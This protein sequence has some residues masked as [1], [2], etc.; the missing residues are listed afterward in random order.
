MRNQNKIKRSKRSR[1]NDAKMTI[2]RAPQHKSNITFTHTYRFVSSSA[3][4]TSVTLSEVIGIA[5][6]Y[7][8]AA[9]GYKCVADAVKIHKIEAW[10]DAVVTN[11]VDIQWYS[12]LEFIQPVTLQ[13]TCQSTAAPAHILM[14]PPRG[15][16]SQWLSSSVTNPTLFALRSSVGT[17]VDV[18][19][20]HSFY[21][22]EGLG[23]PVVV[24]TTASGAVG[25][26]YYL[27]LDGTTGRY[28]PVDLPTLV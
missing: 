24:S 25:T 10:T 16:F 5:G 23:S 26:F 27:P 4:Q 22:S 19:C 20:S 1:Q 8:Y 3:T 7:Y 15:V 6:A 14:R 2:F 12:G 13:D 21:V 18:T 28:Q 17:V 9:N 11:E